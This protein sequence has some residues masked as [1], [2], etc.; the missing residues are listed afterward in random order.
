MRG[1]M[2]TSSPKFWASSGSALHTATTRST[3]REKR[4]ENGLPNNIDPTKSAPWRE[5]TRTPKGGPQQALLS[6][7]VAYSRKSVVTFS[8]ATLRFVGQKQGS[9]G[10]C[11]S[12][13]SFHRSVDWGRAGPGRAGPATILRSLY[14]NYLPLSSLAL[15]PFV[16]I[17]P[18]HR[19]PALRQNHPRYARKLLSGQSPKPGAH[20]SRQTPSRGYRVRERLHPG[21]GS[22]PQLE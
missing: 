8:N 20:Y 15:R 14:G 9:F 3:A 19:D 7:I 4:I 22:V 1:W 16:R 2:W 18:A 17:S 12:F 10:L 6:G 5:A 21:G 13:C 11:A